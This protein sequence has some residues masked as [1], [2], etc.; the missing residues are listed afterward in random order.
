MWL[1]ALMLGLCCL[2]L[3]GLFFSCNHAAYNESVLI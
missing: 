3:V 2:V 1:V